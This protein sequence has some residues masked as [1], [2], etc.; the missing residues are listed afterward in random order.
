MNE[1]LFLFHC[2]ALVGFIL[3]ALR[4][5][6]EALIATLAVQIILANLFVMKQM[7]CFGLNVTCS[8]VYTIGSI[9][10]MNLLQVYFGKKLANK[11]LGIIFFLLF[12]VIVMSQLH[13]RYLPSK[14]DGTQSGFA[15]IL[16]HAPRIM[17]TSFISAFIT[18]KIDI[19]LFG[20]IKKRLPRVPFFVPFALAAV[21]S[22][23]LDTVF[24]S[25]VALYG[26]VHSLR[27][28]ILMSYTVK[29]LTVLTIAPFTLLV[30]KL[31]RH[32]P[33]QV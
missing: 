17:F 11:S 1:I 26:I 21:V 9:F 28:I 10:S 13:L 33:V 27:D 24:F 30:K 16:G 23:F 14:F 7:T 19:E 2:I 15:L 12:F 31:M 25:T 18:Q 4:I 6:K 20:W 5:G 29:I 8:E 3:I 22:Q 32:D